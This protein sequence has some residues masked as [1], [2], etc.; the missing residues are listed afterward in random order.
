MIFSLSELERKIEQH[1]IYVIETKSR[2]VPCCLET[3]Q[4]SESFAEIQNESKKSAVAT[5][6]RKRE[7][8]VILLFYYF[9]SLFIP[10]TRRDTLIS[11]INKIIG[12]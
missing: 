12:F 5:I 8:G 11:L 9:I 4:F 6:K 3:D 10:F 2:V 7:K 1:Y